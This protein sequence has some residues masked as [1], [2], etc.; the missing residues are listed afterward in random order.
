[1]ECKP[2]ITVLK[3]LLYTKTA[4]Q[5]DTVQSGFP[6]IY[7]TPANSGEGSIAKSNTAEEEGKK[8]RHDNEDGNNSGVL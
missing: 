4:L 6:H 5:T 7:E 2:E 3:G 1:M 8:G